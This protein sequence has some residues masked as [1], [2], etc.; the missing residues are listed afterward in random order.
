MPGTAGAV[1]APWSLHITT[2]LVQNGNCPREF[3][4]QTRAVTR[5]TLLP[6]SLPLLLPDLLIP[7]MNIRRLGQEH[8]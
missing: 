7:E 1:V 6:L 3:V 5:H 8:T 2:I 4:L